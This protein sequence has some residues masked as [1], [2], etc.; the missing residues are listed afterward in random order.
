[1]RKIAR[2]IL[3][4]LMVSTVFWSFPAIMS[5]QSS[6]QYLDSVIYL[7]KQCPFIKSECMY[8]GKVAKEVVYSSWD[9][10][11][12]RWKVYK[13][14]SREYDASCNCVGETIYTLRNGG[15]SNAYRYS[16]EYNAENRIVSS[17]Y[18]R[19]EA[20]KN[21]WDD[22]CRWQYQYNANGSMVKKEESHCLDGEW[23]KKYEESYSYDHAGR[24]TNYVL[25]SFEGDDCNGNK[26]EKYD[27][28]ENGLV[29]TVEGFYTGGHWG[30]KSEKVQFRYDGKGNLTQKDTW[31]GKQDELNHVETAAYLY[32]M[33]TASSDVVAGDLRPFYEGLDRIVTYQDILVSKN[34]PLSKIEQSDGGYSE[35]TLYFYSG[36]SPKANQ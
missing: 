27:Y 25:L 13:K 19:W 22:V 16:S 3:L 31:I 21:G 34:K 33:N 17:L 14:C 7:R 6:V 11:A 36:K 8:D 10:S 5:A 9:A 24:R 23:K 1:M 28:G 12:S 30:E 32:D 15:W 29:S 18:Q 26:T 2:F 35:T 4:L 20:E